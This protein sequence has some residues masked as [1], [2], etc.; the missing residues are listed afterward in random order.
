MFWKKEILDGVKIHRSCNTPYAT[1]VPST[2][3]I[4]NCYISRQYV[5]QLQM[6]TLVK[7]PAWKGV[8]RL[9]IIVK[10]KHLFWKC[11]DLCCE[12]LYFQISDGVGQLYCCRS[13]YILLWWALFADMPVH[14]H[15]YKPSSQIP[16]LGDEKKRFHFGQ[17]WYVSLF[18]MLSKI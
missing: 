4:K 6:S 14:I 1:C 17:F 8:L 5:M 11:T 16:I 13:Q 10:K 15:L 9:K 3:T 7:Q 12:R 2:L 18:V